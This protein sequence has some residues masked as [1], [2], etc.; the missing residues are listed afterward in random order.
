MK[1]KIG[2]SLMEM[3]IVLLI[4]AIVAAATAP[5]VSK[6]MARDTGNASPWVFT[7]LDNSITFNPS[8]D[9]NSSVIIGST[10]VKRAGNQS[11]P[12]LYIESSGN[13]PQ[14]GFATRN[15]DRYS[16]ILI[17]NT[18][19]RV[20]LTDMNTVPDNSV[21][22]G[23]NMPELASGESGIIAIGT[24]TQCDGLISYGYT[25]GAISIGN[26]AYTNGPGCI[27]LGESARA[28]SDYSIYQA[29]RP[30]GGTIAIGRNAQASEIGSIAIGGSSDYMQGARATTCY[31][32]AIGADSIAKG[33]EYGYIGGISIGGS[34]NSDKS[35]SIGNSAI[36]DEYSVAIGNSAEANTSYS[37]SIG[38]DA[39][40]NVQHSVAIGADANNSGSYSVVLGDDATNS[41]QHSVAIGADATNSGSYSVALGDDATINNKNSVAI[42]ASSAISGGD[43]SVAIG[44][45]S[46]AL[47]HYAVA[48]GSG[49]I[50]KTY[51]SIALGWQAASGNAGGGGS[52]T[53]AISIGA[54]STAYGKDSIAI[55]T[56]AYASGTDSV[57]IGHN[58]SVTQSHRIQL[59]TSSETVYIPGNLTVNGTFT[60]QTSSDRRLKN[61][62]EK[63][64]A[65]LAELKKL[66][67]FHYT[68]KKDDEKTPHVGVIAQDL[69]KVFPDAVTKGEDGYLSIRWEDMFYA[70]I[71]AIKELDDK[72]IKI[73]QDITN[74]NS[75]II[76]QSET[77]NKQQKT[78]EE[79]KKELNEQAK[80]QKELIMRIERIEKK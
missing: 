22:L 27:A 3:M 23:T 1:F 80:V 46:S 7:G 35:I 30:A 67:A 60:G 13:E 71:N 19:H 53:G 33:I 45:D 36:S 65:G 59:G 32:I 9:N 57:A 15:Q 70:I 78:I 56:D 72:I 43:N 21:V 28:N 79:L 20:G 69:Q 5:M 38:D 11:I 34:S 6:K 18:N 41:V 47:W 44:Y 55:G 24:G 64:T 51:G 52:N 42:G 63:Y 4:V 76:K 29:L 58:V 37:V 16:S 49:S 39:T 8:G 25:N 14:L 54:R 10:Q 74:I 26:Q 2:F 68:F 75:I 12:K 66:D 62:G 77:I 50:A 31:G 40:N 73:T 61:V 48:A 17:D